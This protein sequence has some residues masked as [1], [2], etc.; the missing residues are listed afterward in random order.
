MQTFTF[1]LDLW[2]RLAMGNP[3]VRVTDRIEAVATLL[4]VLV[5]IVA[6]PIAGATGT[7]V[8]DG[9]V[10][11]F[12]AER[13]HQHEVQAVAVKD[14][15]LRPQ[16]YERAHLTEI[17]W[18]Y[19][20]SLHTDEIRTGELK[21]G[22]RVTVWVDDVGNRV[23]KVPTDADAAVQAVIVALTLWVAVVASTSTVWALLRMHLN[24]L[25]FEAWEHELD[26]L[27]D[28]GGRANNAT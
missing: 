3:L 9:L 19:A 10:H 4:V 12:A 5:A 20:G 13:P 6:I 25:R 14:S 24:R 2:K 8:H 1:R 21:A 18:E 22:E 17:R 15:R 11:T 27:A 28:N 16:P 23:R 26:D 7:A